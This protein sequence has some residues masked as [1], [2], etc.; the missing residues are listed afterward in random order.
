MINGV[1]GWRNTKARLKCVQER[2]GNTMVT[3]TIDASSEGYK[4]EQRDGVIAWGSCGI[5]GRFVW[6]SL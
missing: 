2:I 5:K 4:E 6:F 1:S 3:V